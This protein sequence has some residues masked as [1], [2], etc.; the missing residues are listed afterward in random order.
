M[1]AGDGRGPRGVPR[2]ELQT[3]AANGL[4]LLG[5][6]GPSEADLR[7]VR[8]IRRLRRDLG[9]S[10]EAIEIV[11]RLIDRLEAAEQQP[12][13]EPRASVRITVVGR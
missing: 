3:Y 4:L 2:R 5:E 11:M 6:G 10:Y 8:R 9:L 13:S 1:P 12:R 7:R